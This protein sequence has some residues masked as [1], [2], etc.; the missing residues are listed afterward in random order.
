M[1]NNFIKSENF[2]NNLNALFKVLLLLSNLKSIAL[3]S[4]LLLL[5]Y[6]HFVSFLSNNN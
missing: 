4:A 1:S 5:I 6:I 2:N 3:L